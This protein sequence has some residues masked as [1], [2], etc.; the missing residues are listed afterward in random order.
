M[1][2]SVTAFNSDVWNDE[3]LQEVH[4]L[5][6]LLATFMHGKSLKQNTKSFSLVLSARPLM[7]Q[8]RILGKF[9]K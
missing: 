1:A 2:S 5:H 6:Y 9:I 3:L 7:A 4:V 8:R